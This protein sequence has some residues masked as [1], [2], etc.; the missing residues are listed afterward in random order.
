MIDKILKRVSFL[1][2]I[3]ACFALIV[4]A[5]CASAATNYSTYSDTLS[6]NSQVVSLLSLRKLSDASK[7][8]VCFRA[9]QYRYLL[10]VGFD[11]TQTGS[12]SLSFSDCLIYEYDSSITGNST[13]YKLYTGQTGSI[14]VNHIVC[15]D[16]IEFSSKADSSPIWLN[17]IYIFLVV[18][19]FILLLNLLRRFK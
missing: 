5:S 8:Y 6:N 18:I 10:V 4:E 7:H 19:A 12:R 9:S 15:S 17:F 13:R 2:L 1:A 14:S 3:S 16:V 11:I